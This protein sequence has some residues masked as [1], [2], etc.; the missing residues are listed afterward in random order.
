MFKYLHFYEIVKQHS[1]GWCQGAAVKFCMVITIQCAVGSSWSLYR[2]NPRPVFRWLS[3]RVPGSILFTEKTRNDADRGN[4]YASSKPEHFHENQRCAVTHKVHILSVTYITV[5][6]CNRMPGSICHPVSPLLR[7]R[8]SSANMLY[9]VICL[10]C[11]IAFVFRSW[12]WK[13]VCLNSSR[14]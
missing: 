2:L 8:L 13:Y 5:T 10:H 4:C 9:S 7:E 1:T 6:V 3:R 12:Q 14:S 11:I